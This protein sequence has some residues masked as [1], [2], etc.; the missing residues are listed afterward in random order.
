MNIGIGTAEVG[1][2][3]RNL[4]TEE[5]FFVTAYDPKSRTIEVQSLDGDV[6]EIDEEAWSTL[7]LELSEQ[8]EVDTE[9][10]A[11]LDDAY[12]DD[13]RTPIWKAASNGDA[14]EPG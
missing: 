8:P 2:W 1:N 14:A 5:L 13:V 3:Y 7:P 12:P 9:D 4:R 10:V 6:S 11:G